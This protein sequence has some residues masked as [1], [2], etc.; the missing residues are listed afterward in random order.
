MLFDILYY[1]LG[2][3]SLFNLTFYISGGILF[4]IDY[5]RKLINYK[6]QQSDL[7]LN[8]KK[9]IGTVLCNTVIATI[10]LSM[11]FGYYEH[12]YTSSFNIYHL[13]LD[14]AIA[15]V[16][17]EILF[18]GMHRIL[19]FEPFYKYFHK[20]HHEI[21]A[22]I[23]ISAVYMTVT[24]FYLGNVLP[25]YLPM[26]IIK[27]HPLTIKIWCVITTLTAIIGGHSG[28]KYIS[29]SHDYHH[30]LFNKNY[31]TGLFMDKLLG[32]YKN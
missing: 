31:G 4:L 9:C 7:M 24:D 22:P 21:I 6:I 26:I 11:I 5:L 18:Y 16:L 20:K 13:F 8:Y 19:H 2:G 14:M 23:G 12:N 3:Y 25:I 32:T 28:F 29:E 17:T 1:A 10:P 15:R 30:S 27:A